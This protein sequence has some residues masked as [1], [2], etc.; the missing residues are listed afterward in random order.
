MADE[1]GRF[2]DDQQVV[3]FVDNLE[4]LFHA[5]RPGVKPGLRPSL[6]PELVR[7]GGWRIIAGCEREVECLAA[8]GAHAGFRADALAG[9]AAAELQRGLRPGVLRRGLSTAPDGMVAAV[10]DDAGHRPVGE[11]AL[12]AAL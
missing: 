11:P 6:W 9:S 1:I 12:P 8:S 5:T 7:P 2:V 10:L 4:Q 3:V